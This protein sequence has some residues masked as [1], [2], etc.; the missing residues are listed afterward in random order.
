[1]QAITT[2][3]PI[4]DFGNGFTLNLTG[5]PWRSA[6]VRAGVWA[7]SGYGKSYL[8]TVLAEELARLGVPFMIIDPKGGYRALSFLEG[9]DIAVVRSRGGDIDLDVSKNDW[10]R[11]A[12]NLLGRGAGIVVDI[13]DLWVDQGLAYT[14]LLEYL[15]RVQYE[16]WE[17]GQPDGMILM[18]EE[19][20]LFA[21]QKWQS[22]MPSLR[23]TDRIARMGRTYGI[24]TIFCTQ[25]PGDLEKNIIAQ[26]NLRWIGYLPYD[27]DYK[28]VETL[29]GAGQAK[30]QAGRAVR[31]PKGF[32]PPVEGKIRHSD[33]LA[34]KPGEFYVVIG[35][36]RYKF[37]PVRR[38][39]TPDLE[40]TP[41]ILQR[42][43][44]DLEALEV[45][46]EE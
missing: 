7:A 31:V 26:S 33:L 38:R 27:G 21:P 41:P 20:H 1:M 35:Y 34:L 9:V 24:N 28:A 46:K 37:G 25:R 2:V 8:T 5:Q 13:S 43:L 17:Q 30:N 29:L 42:V 45:R 12:V 32:I 23:I 15:Y 6:G 14:A 4:I 16:K 22:D 11:E 10:I 44:F 40:Q 3:T 19:A 18:V 39:W 36:K